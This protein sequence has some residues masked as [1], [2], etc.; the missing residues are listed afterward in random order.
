MDEVVGQTSSLEAF[1]ER[2]QV[3]LVSRSEGDGVRAL[4]ELSC[5]GGVTRGVDA[6]S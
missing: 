4:G 3:S 6:L 2:T 5:P 1:G